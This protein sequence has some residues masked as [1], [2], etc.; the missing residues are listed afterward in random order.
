MI[1]SF[2]ALDFETANFQRNSACAIG[3]VRVDN[4][5]II[6]KEHRLINPQDYFNNACIEIHSITPEDVE[7]APYFPEVWKELLPILEGAE[8]IAAHN[9]S[10]DKA[11][12]YECCKYHSMSPPDH[13]FVCTVQLARKRVPELEN[14]L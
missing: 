5:K 9:A 1:P 14:H 2:V 4:G 13:K 8:F 3:L 6:A 10:F 7:N 12:L 11:V